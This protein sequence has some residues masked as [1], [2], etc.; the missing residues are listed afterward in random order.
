MIRN[1]SVKKLIVDGNSYTD[2]AQSPFAL[3]GCYL[4]GKIRDSLSTSNKPPVSYYGV[5]G[6]EVRQLVTSLPSKFGSV[7]KPNDVVFMNECLNDLRIHLDPVATYNYTVAYCNLVKSYGAKVYIANMIACSSAI[8]FDDTKRTTLNALLAAIPSN[9][10][11][12]VIDVAS[13]PQFSTVAA[14]SNTNYYYVD[15]AHLSATNILGYDTYAQKIAS[16]LDFEFP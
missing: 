4:P 9:V 2:L 1:S 15:G 3:G 6:I 11:D 10:C 7:I 13:L 8:M 14:T 5:S 16:I 12:G